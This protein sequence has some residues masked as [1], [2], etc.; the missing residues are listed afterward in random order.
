MTFPVIRPELSAHHE[1]ILFKCAPSLI[2]RV[3]LRIVSR[4]TKIG[5]T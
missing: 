5:E 1:D 2:A 3:Y 4:I